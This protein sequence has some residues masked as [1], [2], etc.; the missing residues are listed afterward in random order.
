M[1]NSKQDILTLSLDEIKNF[2]TKKGEKAFRAKQIYEWL[3]K[4]PVISFVTW[5]VSFVLPVK[6]V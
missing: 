5:D 3:W 6:W 1:E 2:L 4:K